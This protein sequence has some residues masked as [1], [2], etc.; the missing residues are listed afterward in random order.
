MLVAQI[1]KTLF[2]IALMGAFG[3]SL[4]YFVIT[5]FSLTISKLSNPFSPILSEDLCPKVTI[6]IP[7]YNETAALNCAEKCVHFNYPKN[8]LQIIIGDDSDKSDV[9][10]LI[11]DFIIKYP[12]VLVSRRG[13]NKGFKP[14]NLNAMLNMSTGDYILILDSDF[15]P[16][17]DF[18]LKLVQPVIKNPNLSGVQAGWKII[19]VQKNFSTI[20]GGGIVNVV[21]SILLPFMHKFTNHSILCGSGELVKK[22]DL[23]D[24]NGWTEGSLTEDVDYSLRLIAAG[25]RIE[26]LG[27]LKISCEVPYTAMDLFRQQMRWAYGV[28]SAFLN[29]NKKL[30]KSRLTKRRVKIATFLFS[31]G[32]LMIGLLLFTFF[33]GCLNMLCGAFGINPSESPTSSYTVGSFVYDSTVNL[34]LTGGMLLSSIV[35]AFINGFGLKGSLKLFFATIS[36]GF[37]CM[38]FVG[39]GIFNACFG[40]PMQWFML[41]KMG[42]QRRV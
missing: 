21:H 8:K 24:L 35:A 29:H 2:E 15:L 40:L 20:M 6:Q 38:F 30:L 5:M 41:K 34:F 3:F 12:D 25:K 17:N 10:K 26:Y 39:K 19:N 18:L 27:Q 23:I 7:T 31:I 42:N 1:I 33:F 14:G 37:V 4:I 9:S 13:S 22:S 28:V 36:I 32:Y 11:D 16:N